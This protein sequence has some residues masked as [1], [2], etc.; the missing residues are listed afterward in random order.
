MWIPLINLN[1]KTTKGNCIVN[2]TYICSFSHGVD[3]PFSVLDLLLSWGHRHTLVLGL[4]FTS[5]PPSPGT[6]QRK[7]QQF[8]A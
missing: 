7:R 1:I 6:D 4:N 5:A 2:L 8:C 3:P